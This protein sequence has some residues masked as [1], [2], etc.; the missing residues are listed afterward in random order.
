VKNGTADPHD[1]EMVPSVAFMKP[2]TN[3]DQ[4][5]EGYSSIR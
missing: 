2:T 3:A 4:I 5:P 1:E